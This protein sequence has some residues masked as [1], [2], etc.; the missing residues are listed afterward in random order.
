MPI[1]FGQPYL[2]DLQE[3]LA[4]YLR[5]WEGCYGVWMALQN[6]CWNLF[7]TVIVLTSGTNKKWLGY[8]GSAL[9]NGLML[10]SWELVHYFG[11]GLL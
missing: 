2:Q 5:I 10:L 7:A 11:S 8:E 9:M 1:P 6:L 3:S 4:V